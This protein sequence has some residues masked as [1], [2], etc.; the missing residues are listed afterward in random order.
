MTHEP[1]EEMLAR[2]TE[3]APNEE[4]RL[5]AHLHE[6]PQCQATA[7]AYQEQTRLLRSIPAVDPPSTLRAGVFAGI[8]AQPARRRFVWPVRA[9]A[10]AA[11]LA[12]VAAVAIVV[13]LNSHPRPANTAAP[14]V[15]TSPALNT[16]K[17]GLDSAQHSGGHHGSTAKQ[18]PK[19]HVP[20]GSKPSAGGYV[21]RY[22]VNGSTTSAGGSPPSASTAPTAQ[23][24]GNGGLPLQGPATAL[25]SRNAAGRI[26]SAPVVPQYTPVPA[27]TVGPPAVHPVS[28]PTAIIAPPADTPVPAPTVMIQAGTAPTSTPTPTPVP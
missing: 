22:G 26:R 12:A 25:P 16:K 19:S 27:A 10:F 14:A 17:S 20:S 6:C 15:P 9:A 28:H 24:N 3:L 23:P 18:Q 13:A 2:R 21:P 1:F 7:A 5:A 8:A 4:R 11:P